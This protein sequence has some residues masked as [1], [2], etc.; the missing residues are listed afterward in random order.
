M[1]QSGFTLLEIIVVV[2]IIAI[3]TSAAFLNTGS[4]PRDKHVMQEGKR[5][6]FFLQMA[7]DDAV[8]RNA[9]LGF[10]LT[11][12]QIH[13]YKW[14]LLKAADENDPESVDDYDWEP[15]ESR[16]VKTFELPEDYF[17]ELNIEGQD[18]IL[19]YDVPEKEILPQ[20]II[21]STGEQPISEFTINIEEFN[22]ASMVSGSGV[23]R[24]DTDMV[25]FDG[26]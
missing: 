6:Q 2:F 1:K 23:G 21:Y 15:Y 19:P 3:M 20:F 8:F 17:F 5:L 12:N 24:F 10:F 7:S 11:R 22:K 26:I 13:P 25:T 18:L 9:D 16:L 4:D 14:V